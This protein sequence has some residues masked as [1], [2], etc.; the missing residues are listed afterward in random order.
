MTTSGDK[1]RA[2]SGPAILSFGFR[3]FFLLGAIWAALAMALWMVLLTLAALAFWVV[4][5][6][7]PGV[8]VGLALV[9]VAQAWRLSRW[10]GH[11]ARAEPL[12]WVLHVGYGFV[13]LG[14]LAVA[15]ARVLPGMAPAALHVWL[16]GAVGLMTLAVMTR[17]SLGHA[18]RPLHASRPITALYLALIVSV[19][20]RLAAAAFP[21]QGWLLYLAASAWIAAFGGFAVIYWPI[22]ARPRSARPMPTGA[23]RARG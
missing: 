17:A 14:F 8:A 7:R 4:W 22:L 20:A 21:G 15:M 16:A 9:A 6:D 12:V 2:W 5:P 10:A 19:L 18:G 3:P 13:P 23:A 11:L 1:M